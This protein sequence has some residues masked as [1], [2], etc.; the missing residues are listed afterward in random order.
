MITLPPLKRA[1][2][3]DIQK[4]FSFVKKIE[5]DTS[6]ETGGEIEISQNKNTPNAFGFSQA[7]YL[8]KHQE[9]LKDWDKRLYYNFTGTIWRNPDGSR[10]V[11]FLYWDGGEWVLYWHWL[12]FDFDAVDRIVALRASNSSETL[13]LASR[14][15]ALE[16]KMSKI[17]KF[18]II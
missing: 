5:S 12:G 4:S 14:V 10:C 18:L 6:P 9:L 11:P 13:S 7:K 8:S 16:E 15:K 1:T 3:K 17:E 2:L